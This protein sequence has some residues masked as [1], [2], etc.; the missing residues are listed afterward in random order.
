MQ[1][2][3]PI[4]MH[5]VLKHRLH[6]AIA[7]SIIVILSSSGDKG[8]FDVNEFAT[9]ITDEVITVIDNLEKDI[10]LIEQKISEQ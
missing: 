10:Q 8:Q 5:D 3:Q 6:T 9:R 2:E 7:G 1:E 4:T